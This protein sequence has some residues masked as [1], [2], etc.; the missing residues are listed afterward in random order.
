[1][2]LYRNHLSLSVCPVIQFLCRLQSK[3]TL[4][5]HFV[6]RLSV[7][8]SVTLYYQSPQA[9]QVFYKYLV[10]TKGQKQKMCVS[11]DISKIYYGR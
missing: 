9:T 6:R 11:S 2:G 8:P 7:R 10:K 4:R 5:D 3:A 1:M